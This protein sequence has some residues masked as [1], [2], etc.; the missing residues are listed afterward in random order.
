MAIINIENL[1]AVQWDKSNLWDITIDDMPTSPFTG[2]IPVNDVQLGFF[3]VSGE[4]IGSTGLEIPYTR[5]VPTFNLS[6]Y[7]DEELTITK[8]FTD[9][10]KSMVSDDGYD[11]MLLEDAQKKITIQKLNSVLDEATQ[12]WIFNAYPTGNIEY[13]GDSD[14]SL[15][16]YSLTFT[17]SGGN[18]SL[19]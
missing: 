1:R 4:S 2:W 19:L 8:F 10:L 6:Y 11:V 17:V 13:H 3:G 15:S 12:T 16:V 7:D 18:M 14:G 5:T 9:W